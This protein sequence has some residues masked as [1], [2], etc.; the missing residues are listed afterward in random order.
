MGFP[1]RWVERSGPFGLSAPKALKGRLR[2][3]PGEFLEHRHMGY[4]DTRAKSN[5]PRWGPSVSIRDAGSTRPNLRWAAQS[6]R[7]PTKSSFLQPSREFPLLSGR[8]AM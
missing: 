6:C 1:A 5:E 2:R 8:P 7:Y 4:G 3:I